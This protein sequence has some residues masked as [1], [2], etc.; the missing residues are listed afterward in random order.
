MKREEKKQETA[1]RIIDVALRLFSEK[2]YEAT[3]V[4]EITRAAG[5]AK[6]TFFNYFKTKEE[7]LVKFQK[8]LFF[9]EIKALKDKSGPLVPR[10]LAF[11]KELGDSMDAD[12][13]HMRLTLQRFLMT[14]A[15]DS[16]N[17]NLS[18]KAETMIP[19]FEKGQQMG[20][21]DPAVPP[22][23]MAR[24]ALQIYLGTLFAWST[25][26]EKE[27]LGEQLVSAYRIFLKGI[28]LT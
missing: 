16:D 10:M 5:V 4:A 3:T 1:G 19:L 15:D 14:H 22:A 20:E 13:T 17:C 8:A 7:L 6:G 21:F 9:N 23:E 28:T 18:D 12:R 24:L 2:G 25:S 26:D 11:V 27:S